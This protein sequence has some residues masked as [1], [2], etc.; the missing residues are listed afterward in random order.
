MGQASGSK[1]ATGSATAQKK[2]SE[3]SALDRLKHIQSNFKQH[4]KGINCEFA[5]RPGTSNFVNRKRTFTVSDGAVQEE[6]RQRQL[7]KVMCKLKDL[8]DEC[9]GVM[10]GGSNQSS[11]TGGS[12]T[13]S[14]RTVSS[15]M[16]GTHGAAGFF[17]GQGPNQT[18]YYNNKNNSEFLVFKNISEKQ[19][20]TNTI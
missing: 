15:S 18:G 10:P 14:N 3:M 11:T 13:I 2:P 9:K 8:E 19:M 12:T 4:W 1:Q 6:E 5:G 16:S 20:V 7:G 17:N